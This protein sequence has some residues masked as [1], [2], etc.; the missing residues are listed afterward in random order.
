MKWRGRSPRWV[1]VIWLVEKT[2]QNNSTNSLKCLLCIQYWFR[3]SDQVTPLKENKM[4]LGRWKAYLARGFKTVA[5]G[6]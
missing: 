5:C 3:D 6:I 4:K 2:F 1:L